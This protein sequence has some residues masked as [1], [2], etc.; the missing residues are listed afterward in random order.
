[1]TSPKPSLNQFLEAYS[2]GFHKEPFLEKFHEKGIDPIGQRRKKREEVNMNQKE[3]GLHE[4]RFKI[5][6]DVNTHFKLSNA[7]TTTEFHVNVWF[8]YV[9][10]VSGKT[11]IE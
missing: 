9:N 8:V 1:M 10:C 7:L 2:W 5:E 4:S 6:L 3:K 11:I